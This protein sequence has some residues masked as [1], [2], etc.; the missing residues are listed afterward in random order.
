MRIL[1]ERTLFKILVNGDGALVSITTKSR[2]YYFFLS[3]AYV[4]ARVAPTTDPFP[5]IVEV[6]GYNIRRI[7]REWDRLSR[8]KLVA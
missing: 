6:C 1:N 7:V 2:A 4:G 8:I 5:G 3:A